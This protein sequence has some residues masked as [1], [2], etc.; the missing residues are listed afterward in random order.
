MEVNRV[1][2]LFCFHLQKV[3]K[4]EFIQV[5]R[6]CAGSHPCP[7]VGTGWLSGCQALQFSLKAEVIFAVGLAIGGFVVPLFLNNRAPAGATEQA[8]NQETC[9]LYVATC[10]TV[11]M[12]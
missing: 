11:P 5:S 9:T 4:D 6:L 2:H 1:L 7:G 12:R 3:F 8:S 10:H